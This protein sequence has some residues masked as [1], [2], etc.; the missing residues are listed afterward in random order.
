MRPASTRPYRG[1]QPAQRLAQ[2]HARLLDAGLSILGGEAGPEALTVRGVCRHAGVATRYFYE[3]FADRDDMVGAVFDWVIADLAAATQAAVAAAPARELTRTAMAT[4]VRAITDDPRIGRLL[5]SF[6]HAD[7]V[8][9]RKRL[10]SGAL[11][12]MLSGQ[13]AGQALQLTQNE[14]I[15]ATAYFVVGGVSSTLST[16]LA[17]DVTLTAEQL[18]DQLTSVINHLGDR[19]LYQD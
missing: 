19:A 13:H 4:I 8:L 15:R 11:F 14:R 17:G 7:T 12:A 2:R 16:W 18:V 5:F 10:E 1:I 6:E 9:V 3:S